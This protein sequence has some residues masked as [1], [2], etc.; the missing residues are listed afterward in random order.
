MS[1]LGKIGFEYRKA[2]SQV[3]DVSAAD[4]AGAGSD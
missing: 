3:R 2:P 1:V 4:P